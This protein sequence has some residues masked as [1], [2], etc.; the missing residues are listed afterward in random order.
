MAGRAQDVEPG[1]G[2]GI[3]EV[4]ELALEASATITEKLSDGT[5]ILR[6]FIVKEPTRALGIAVGMGVLLGWLIKR[7]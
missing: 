7:R 2:L 1:L 6:G 4:K 3:G 5:R